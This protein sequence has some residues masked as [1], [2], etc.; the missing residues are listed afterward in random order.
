MVYGCVTD[1]PQCHT[2]RTPNR[3]DSVRWTCSLFVRLA[4]AVWLFLIAHL[5]SFRLLFGLLLSLRVFHF[6]LGR[7]LWLSRPTPKEFAVHNFINCGFV[8]FCG[9]CA[10]SFLVIGHA[11]MRWLCWRAVAA[12]AIDPSYPTKSEQSD[13]RQFYFI[14]ILSVLCV[15]SAVLVYFCICRAAQR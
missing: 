11:E 13:N 7:H 15:A 9:L 1:M 12:V 4:D 10:F 2:H 6:H 8:L 3:Q 5:I 14:H